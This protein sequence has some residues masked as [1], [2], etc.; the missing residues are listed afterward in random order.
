L[1]S[2]PLKNKDRHNLFGRK[3]RELRKMLQKA[4]LPELVEAFLD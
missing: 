1:A 4:R 3:H 2:L